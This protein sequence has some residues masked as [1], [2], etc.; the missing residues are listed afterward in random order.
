M[1]NPK[2]PY[3]TSP[4]CRV[5]WEKV[6]RNSQTNE[7]ECQVVSDFLLKNTQADALPKIEDVE[8]LNRLYP[9]KERSLY[10][11]DTFRVCHCLCAVCVLT[12]LICFV[13]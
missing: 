9:N 5:L 1:I 12:I 10:F 11:Y 6:R 13:M 3:F 2:R 4:E 8:V 7:Q